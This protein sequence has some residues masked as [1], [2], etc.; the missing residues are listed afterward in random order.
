M[1]ESQGCGL[2][3]S[4]EGGMTCRASVPVKIRG[5]GVEGEE[6]LRS[7]PS[8]EP[9]LSAFLLPCGTVRLLGWPQKLDGF[10]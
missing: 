9:K 6:F 5:S 8:L 7:L 2:V 4:S 10:E 3:G 1:P